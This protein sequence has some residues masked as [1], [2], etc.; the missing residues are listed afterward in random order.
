[1][2]SFTVVIAIVTFIESEMELATWVLLLST[3]LGP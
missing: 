2:G 1:M 3:I